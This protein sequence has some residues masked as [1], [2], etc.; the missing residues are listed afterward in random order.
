MCT[1]TAVGFVLVRNRINCIVASIIVSL[2]CS[3]NWT[4][5]PKKKTN[6]TEKSLYG[7]WRV[8][9]PNILDTLCVCTELNALI[10]ISFLKI[11]ENSLH[12]HTKYDMADWP[13]KRKTK[14][15]GTKETSHRTRTHTCHYYY[16][17]CYFCYH[18]KKSDHTIKKEDVNASSISR[19]NK[20]KQLLVC[21][22]IC[23]CLSF[24][25]HKICSK[26]LIWFDCGG[27]AVLLKSNQ[28]QL[29]YAKLTAA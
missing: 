7:R 25:S 10:D 18:E 1:E 2:F 6:S 17:W 21:K 28:F 14:T 23:F 24:Q 12:T 3:E 11:Y 20:I 16:C 22:G 26:E 19:N 13:N 15:F 5:K 8:V 9:N 29:H 4:Q 27:F